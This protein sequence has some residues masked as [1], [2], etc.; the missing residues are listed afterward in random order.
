MHCRTAPMEEARKLYI[1]QSHL[2]ERLSLSEGETTEKANALTI[3]DVG[4][5]AAANAMAAVHCYE[6]AAAKGAVRPLRIF[7]F[8]NDLDALRLAF[9]HNRDFTYLRHSGPAAILERAEWHSARYPGLTWTL[10][11]GDFAQMISVAPLPDLIFYDMFSSQSS[12]DQ[13]TFALFRK[14]FAACTGR[15]VELFTYTRS[16]ANRAA[17]LA[18][19]FY[20]AAGR[21]AGEK[22][23]TTIALTPEAL[24]E[25]SPYRHEL[26]ANEWLAKWNRSGAKFPSDMPAEECPGFEK[27]I[28]GHEQFQS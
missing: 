21:S 2:S 24:P 20:V 8:E 14:V 9:R 6:E 16:T 12:S 1:E 23:E 22:E 27:V 18:A 15:P 28:R 11:E 25:R 10:L 3:W 13:W 17:L 5:G 7:S 26:L 4:L 19:G